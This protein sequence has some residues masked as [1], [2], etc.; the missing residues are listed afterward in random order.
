MAQLSFPDPRLRAPS[1]EAR[2]RGWN[3]RVALIVLWCV[4]LHLRHNAG[5]LD[6]F[7]LP[8]S[9]RTARFRAHLLQYRLIAQR[10]PWERSVVILA[11]LRVTDARLRAPARLAARALEVSLRVALK[12][13]QSARL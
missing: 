5:N 1:R 4:R 9:F 7:Q 2:A 3:L 13:L 6:P 12:A 11:Q 10:S 8:R